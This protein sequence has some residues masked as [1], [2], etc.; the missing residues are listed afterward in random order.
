MVVALLGGLG[1]RARLFEQVGD[2]VSA[3]EPI[4]LVKMDACELRERRWQQPRMGLGS[5]MDRTGGRRRRVTAPC[6]NGMSYGS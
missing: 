5:A 3:D 1:D 4:A 2:H 6:Q